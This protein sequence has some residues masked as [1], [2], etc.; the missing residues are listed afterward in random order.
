MS[1]Y[2]GL[3]VY[4]SFITVPDISSRVFIQFGNREILGFLEL[5]F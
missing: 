2:I 1:A 4:R 5:M 3:N